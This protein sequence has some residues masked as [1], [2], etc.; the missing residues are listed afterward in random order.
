MIGSPRDREALEAGRLRL[1]HWAGPSVTRS[2]R[3]SQRLEQGYHS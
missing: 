3:E 2:A 1:S